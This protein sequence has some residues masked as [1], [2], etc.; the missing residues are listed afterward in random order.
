MKPQRYAI[1]IGDN[2]RL[3]RQKSLE[4]VDSKSDCHVYQKIQQMMPSIL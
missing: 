3:T 2:N 4:T 1:L